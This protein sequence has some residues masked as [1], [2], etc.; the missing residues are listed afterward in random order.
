MKSKMIIRGALVLLALWLLVWLGMSLAGKKKATAER[1]DGM[2]EKADFADWSQNEGSP[3][4]A[5]MRRENLQEVARVL[6]RMDLR[7]REV[8]REQQTGMRLFNKLSD[9][10]RAYFLDLTLT[11]SMKRMMQAF[12]EMKP[13]ERKKFVRQAMENMASGRDGDDLTNLQKENP[14][15][16]DKMVSAGLSA[17]YQDASAETKL[18]LAPFMDSVSQ[19]MQGFARG[20]GG[21]E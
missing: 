2:V 18:D 10:E 1:L 11:E 9:P 8:M 15:L 19:M 3:A 12:D 5:E 7:Q 21:M 20:A 14:E 17:Y 6:N 4:E 16:V 13:E